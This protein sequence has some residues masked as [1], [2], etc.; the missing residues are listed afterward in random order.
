MAQFDFYIKR[1]ESLEQDATFYEVVGETRTVIPLTNVTAK[2]EIRPNPGSGKL[3]ASF[4]CEV[5]AEEGT[6][7][8]QLSPETTA[9]MKKGVYAWDLLMENQPDALTKY[10]IDGLFVVY[11]H[12]TELDL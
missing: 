3:L 6:V 1:G 12:V 11:D 2:A 4:D 5:L 10:P 8:M 7:L 9:G